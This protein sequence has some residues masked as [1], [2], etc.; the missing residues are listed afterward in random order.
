MKKVKSEFAMINYVGSGCFS[1]VYKATDHD[2][3]IVAVK[4]Y[5]KHEPMRGLDREYEVL[6]RL[7]H[8]AIV[9][10]KE[11]LREAKTLIL[12]Y[13][14]GTNIEDGTR[15]EP[16][17]WL[18]DIASAVKHCHDRKIAHRDILPCNVR[19]TPE[20]R[21]KLI[22]FGCATRKPTLK[23]Y[24]YDLE[25]LGDLILSNCFRDRDLTKLGKAAMYSEDI[26]IYE[27]YERLEDIAGCQT[28]NC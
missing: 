28:F 9:K 25:G 21:G 17:P 12:E 27:F 26:D 24:W 4:L 23:D 8:P 10:A 3:Q 20:N 14:P 6:S 22:D 18:L 16:F 2:G 11:Y 15:Y 1:D 13:V 5:S 7:D 19:I